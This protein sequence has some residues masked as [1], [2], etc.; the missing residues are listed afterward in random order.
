VVYS[1]TSSL[2]K[3]FSFTTKDRNSGGGP[4]NRD[5]VTFNAHSRCDLGGTSDSLS[6]T[7]PLL[8]IAELKETQGD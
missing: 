3:D 6:V 5:E 4:G 1:F 7:E 2:P 8:G